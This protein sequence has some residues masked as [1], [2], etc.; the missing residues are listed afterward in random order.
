MA[1]IKCTNDDLGYYVPTINTIIKFGLWINKELT[2]LHH[3]QNLTSL[4]ELKCM[5]GF[6]RITFI[7]KVR[8]LQV[9]KNR[10]SDQ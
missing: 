8:Q 4:G 9:Y 7:T 10:Y 6:I 1:K 2:L 5:Q 3:V